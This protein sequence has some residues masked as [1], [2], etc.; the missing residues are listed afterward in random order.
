MEPVMEIYLLEKAS[1]YIFVVCR[2]VE[3]AY[4]APTQPNMLLTIYSQP[5]QS[6][7]SNPTDGKGMICVWN[8]NEPSYPQRILACESQPRCCCF[9][10]YKTSIAFAGMVS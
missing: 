9:G 1:K 4:F 2:H 7:P 10:P 5:E 8:T 3:F 6:N